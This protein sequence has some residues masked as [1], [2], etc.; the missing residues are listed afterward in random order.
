MIHANERM[1]LGNMNLSESSYRQ[2]HELYNSIHINCSESV[3]A[4][5]QNI[6]EF[7]PELK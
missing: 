4:Q 7:F 3:N 2:E 1:E 6:V 5:R